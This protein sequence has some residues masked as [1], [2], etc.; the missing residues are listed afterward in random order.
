MSTGERLTLSRRLFLQARA[1]YG[2]QIAIE[3]IH[4]GECGPPSSAFRIAFAGVCLS[5]C[6]VLFANG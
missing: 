6:G 2:F 1:F 4:S 5:V 3:N